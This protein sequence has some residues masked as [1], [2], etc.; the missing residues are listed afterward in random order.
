MIASVNHNI[1]ESVVQ[2]ALSQ[3]GNQLTKSLERLASGKRIN[4]AADD[5]AGLSIMKKQEARSR[6][7]RQYR[8]N[9]LV[10]QRILATAEGGAQNISSILLQLKEWSVQAA[11]DTLTRTDRVAIQAAVNAFVNEV[12]F[13][14]AS[15]KFNDRI[16]LD[17]SYDIDVYLPG[18][19]SEIVLNTGS[20][21]NGLTATELGLIQTRS[22]WLP[23]TKDGVASEVTPDTLLNSL[24][25]VI[26][27]LNAGDI[28]HINGTL[29]NGLDIDPNTFLTFTDDTTL[30][31]LLI[32]INDAFNAT[33]LNNGATAEIEQDVNGEY[34]GVLRLTDN[35]LP[36]SI[37]SSQ[38]SIELSMQPGPGSVPPILTGEA[39]ETPLFL[40]IV[41]YVG[42]ID[43]GFVSLDDEEILDLDSTEVTSLRP[44]NRA[45]F[46]RN[47]AIIYN[48][49]DIEFP[50]EVNETNN[51][52]LAEIINDGVSTGQKT[53]TLTSGSFNKEAL[54]VNIN[55]AF[56]E[57]GCEVRASVNSNNSS[58]ARVNIRTQ[59]FADSLVLEDFGALASLGFTGTLES[60][61]GRG[62]GNNG[63]YE[64][65]DVLVTKLN[66]EISWHN[67]FGD[68]IIATTDGNSIS[69]EGI[70]ITSLDI[71]G[72][73]LSRL[74]FST[75]PDP[76]ASIRSMYD[77]APFEP[78][79]EG[80][81]LDVRTRESAIKAIATIDAAIE[82][83]GRFLSNIG[84]LSARF[85]KVESTLSSDILGVDN[86]ISIIG[87]TDYAK[88]TARLVRSQILQQAGLALL[89]QANI[90]PQLVWSL[91]P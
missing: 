15:T 86:I 27:K 5:A 20:D 14:T 33:D 17:G 24:D 8:R 57:V 13:I 85:E 68:K 63:S 41:D 54:E 37:G 3:H 36:S 58:R 91:L 66:E 11:N 29:P 67:R 76:N 78:S 64:S 84:G 31:D 61:S 28:I 75:T 48:T 6:G 18:E 69:F 62:G 46:T 22:L 44:Y 56:A 40:D 35:S 70:G 23:F 30:D 21:Q 19:N 72:S 52:F 65:L 42:I 60:D 83:V 12:D 80:G 2:R 1:A 51:E 26:P 82:I 77:P 45:R 49:S 38:T 10:A 9:T 7:L 34:T 73:A 50:Y 39:I 71:R 89:A 79:P 53:I 90:V 43:F 55:N 81:S 32:E 88:E 4:R 59:D 16:L 47:N 25:K 87:D 74:G